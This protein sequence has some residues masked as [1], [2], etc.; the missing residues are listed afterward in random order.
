MKKSVRVLWGSVVAAS[1][2]LLASCSSGT[3]EAT[4]ASQTP[5][6]SASASASAAADPAAAAAQQKVDEASQAVDTFTPPGPELGDLSSLKG[7]TVYYVAA[8][9]KIPLFHIVGDAMTR[10]LSSAGLEVKVCDGKASPSDM[11]GCLTQAI[12]AKADAV[13]SGSIPD[14]LASV[15]FQQVRDAGI[16]LLYMLT[17]PA[18]PGEP[19]KV[20]YVTPD[21]VALQATNAD[22]VIADS[23]AKANVLVV[24]VTDT[25]ATT[26]WMDQGALAEY[27]KSCPSC[28]V[29]VLETNT[30]QLQKLP[31]LVSSAMVRDPDITYVQAEFDVTVQPVVQ[32]LQSAGKTDGVKIIS[33]DGT[34]AIQQMLAEGRVAATSGVNLDALGWYGADQVLRMMSGQPSVQNLEFPYR[35]LFTADN[36][37]DLDL[38]PEGESSG[39]WFGATDYEDGFKKLWGVA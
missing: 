34:L 19:A 3:N 31:S 2:L 37:K 17:A 7:K 24:K 38:T 18:G 13:V 35:R 22:W 36:V 30:G 15:A 10:A 28:E 32:G 12:D 26:L 29:T 4:G 39:S 25:P 9:Y 21:N 27:E 5:S 23:G 6:S 1:A 20:G 8:N 33:G 11:A 14:D 16:P